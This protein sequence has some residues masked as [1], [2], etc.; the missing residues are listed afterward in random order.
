MKVT[1]KC[2]VGIITVLETIP[3]PMA[4]LPTGN[5]SSGITTRAMTGYESDLDGVAHT[6]ET[7][8]PK[9]ILTGGKINE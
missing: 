8:K 9:Y 6:N 1:E 4:G 3:A 2:L 5:F 7:H